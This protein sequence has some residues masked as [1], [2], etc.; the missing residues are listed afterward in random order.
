[1]WCAAGQLLRTRSLAASRYGDDDFEELTK[2]NKLT[3]PPLWLA[4][5]AGPPPLHENRWY[6]PS[7]DIAE[8]IEDIPDENFLS[9]A[10]PCDVSDYVVVNASIDDRSSRHHQTVRIST[11]LV[12]PATA[13]AL[14]RALQTVKY[15]HDF[16]ICPEGHDCEIAEPGFKLTGWLSSQD[17]D[18]LLDKK[19]LF[20][21]G[22]RRIEFSP[23]KAI[24]RQL[25]L[26]YRIGSGAC[27]FRKDQTTPC[28]IYETWGYQ[29]NEQDRERSYG[30]IPESSGYRL[31]VLKRDLSEF[32]LKKKRDLILEVEITRREPRNP[33]DSDDEKE[34]TEHEFERIFL[35]RRD[36]S[37]QAAERDF[38]SWR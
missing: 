33:R 13:L 20:S 8:W 23:G 14:V 35:L 24:L 16:Y 7:S 30:S 36:G 37:I 3:A 28:F 5:L 1:M 4:D 6:T 21:N 26:E 22:V 32:L 18:S 11:G 2:Y 15:S 29:E 34:P 12:S 27:W 17:G 19:D 25:G 9:E 10:L 38:G 31:L